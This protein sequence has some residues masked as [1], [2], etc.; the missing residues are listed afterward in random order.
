MIL[1]LTILAFILVGGGLFGANFLQNSWTVASDEVKRAIASRIFTI[2]LIALGL[3]FLLPALGGVWG[4]MF[5]GYR[6]VVGVPGVNLG[7]GVI[8]VSFLLS[9]LILGAVALLARSIADVLHFLFPLRVFE[10]I[11]DGI[12][13][14]AVG[15]IMWLFLIGVWLAIIGVYASVEAI[16]FAVMVGVLYWALTEYYGLPTRWVVPA[17]MATIVGVIL[18][19][20]FSA[21]PGSFWLGLGLPNLRP[22]ANFWGGVENVALD[23][24]EK[25]RWGNI[26]AFCSR[27]FTELETQMAG[28]SMP[29][30]PAKKTLFVNLKEACGKGNEIVLAT[31]E[32]KIWPPPSP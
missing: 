19:V 11:R 24:A 18:W 25:A 16:A 26:R 7:R 29:E 9:A 3:A 6:E 23:A 15:G 31:L 14:T 22:T 2:L 21:I 12:W 1:G 13:Y 5:S 27:G 30:L 8:F 10:E 4:W 28:A 20:G 17:G 32:K